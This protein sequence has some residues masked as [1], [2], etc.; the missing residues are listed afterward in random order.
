VSILET[1]TGGVTWLS[2]TV[3][4]EA[5]EGY[6]EMGLGDDRLPKMPA[7][8]AELLR[9]SFERKPDARPRDMVEIATALQDAYRLI[10]SSSY[11]RE[12]PNPTE[13]LADNLNKGRQFRNPK[14]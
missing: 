8:L 2:G 11:P 4:G 9:R 13:A 5:L 7:S 14:S 3:A 12:M 1:F 10:T 6:L